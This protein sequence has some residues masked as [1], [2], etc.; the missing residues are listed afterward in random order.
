MRRRTPIAAYGV[1]IA[2][3]A[4][5]VAGLAA[6]P[7]GTA[8]AAATSGLTAA[9]LPITGYYQMAVDS[10]GSRVFI[11]QG[12]NGS[13][14]IAV[15]DFS[16]NV[17][18]A[19]PE[20]SAVE[21]IALS[22]DGSTLYAAL[23]GSGTVSPAI[24]VISTASLEQTASYP[25]PAGDTPQ[26]VAV[27]SGKLWVSYDPAGADGHAA[28]G[29][30][31]LSAASPALEIQSAMGG[32]YSAPILAADPTG[33]GSVL[34]ATDQNVLDPTV[35]SYDTAADPVTVRAQGAL[36]DCTGDE[37]DYV[38]DIAVVPGGAGFIAPCDTPTGELEYL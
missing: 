29:D 15:T 6:V 26:D 28:I 18:G 25:L 3:G 20:P 8:A 10:A 4:F 30:F 16:G 22:P 9:S 7:A 19:I 1:A 11:S 34:L 13:D 38:I 27:Q 33:N 21:G 2:A 23:V 5:A 37:Y 14:S 24:S 35:A 31:D 32:W 17:A 12:S 36:S